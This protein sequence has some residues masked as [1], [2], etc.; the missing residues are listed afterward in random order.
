MAKRIDD[1]LNAI[2]KARYGEEVRGSIH[3]AIEM[4]SKIAGIEFGNAITSA[5]SP[6]GT[7]EIGTFYFNNVTDDLWKLRDVDDWELVGNIKGQSGTPGADA[8]RPVGVVETS[9]VGLLHTYEIQF[10][11]GTAY[12][13]TVSDG[14]SGSGTGDMTKSV[15]DTD[16]DGI[17]DRSASVGNAITSVLENFDEDSSGNPTYNGKTIGGAVS[18][19]NDTIVKNAAGE[20]EVSSDITD[21]IDQ[22][23]NVAADKDKVLVANGDGTF[24]W[25]IVESSNGYSSFV[26]FT[27]LQGNNHFDNYS[28][29]ISTVLQNASNDANIEFFFELTLKDGSTDEYE[30]VTLASYKLGTGADKGRFEINVVDNVS[31]DVNCRIKV[32]EF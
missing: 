11:D 5:T 15:Y 2:L 17:V 22:L 23:D 14:A 3:D 18:I 25:D 7:Y 19:D 30:N 12:P 6:S 9:H 1:Y 24:R 16:N 21:K 10:D 29:T 13:F 4:I 28:G 27:I 26:D 31:V 20:I 32:T 8:P